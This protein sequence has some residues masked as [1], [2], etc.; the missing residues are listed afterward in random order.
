MDL[1]LPYANAKVISQH[2]TEMC[3]I[4]TAEFSVVY[5]CRHTTEL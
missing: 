1:T 5:S 3:L 4:R 2:S